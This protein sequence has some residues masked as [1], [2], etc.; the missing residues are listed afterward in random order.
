MTCPARPV[1]RRPRRA[2]PGAQPGRLRRFLRQQRGSATI[3]FAMFVPVFLLILFAG[4]ETGVMT[5]RQTML[6]RGMETAMRALRLGQLQPVTLDTLRESVCSDII[7]LPDCEQSLLIELRRLDPENVAL[8]AGN[9]PC[10]N[11]SEETQPAITLTPGVEHD[12]V[13]VRVCAIIDPLFP[14]T[15][16]SLGLPLDD[17]GGFRMT[18]ASVYVNEPR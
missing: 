5:A 4:V 2:R 14:S 7:L 8:P 12:L 3:E 18:T 13:L 6:E 16:P 17:S 15:G 9:A 1:L 10:V 11:R